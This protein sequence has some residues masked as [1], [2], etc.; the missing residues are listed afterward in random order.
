MTFVL[1]RYSWVACRPLPHMNLCASTLK[2]DL[3]H[4]Q[5]HQVD[6]ATVIRFQSFDLQRVGDGFWIKPLAVVLDDDEHSLS[7]RI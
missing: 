5:L 7:Q 3:V 6:A 2:R 1:K 4:R